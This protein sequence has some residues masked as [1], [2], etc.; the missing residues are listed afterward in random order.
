MLIDGYHSRR[1]LDMGAL[2]FFM[3][4]R[5]V[6][7]IGWIITRLGEDGASA[8]NERFLAQAKALITAL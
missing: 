3:A 5:A 2:D 7:Y 1:A 6:T 8:R 4:L